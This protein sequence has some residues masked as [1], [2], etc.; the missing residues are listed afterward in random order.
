M[1]AA[2]L[3]ITTTRF[4]AAPKPAPRRESDFEL[5]ALIAAI[6][7]KDQTAFAKFYDLTSR[8]VFNGGV[9]GQ[10]SD[11]IA[12]PVRFSWKK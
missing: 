8:P 4:P 7:E 5:P 9:S 11:Q 6:A 1:A 12:A 3:A 2:A 10:T